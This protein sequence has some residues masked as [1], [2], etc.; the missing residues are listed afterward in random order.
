MLDEFRQ[1]LRAS[2]SLVAVELAIVAAIFVA[3]RY[4]LIFFSKTPYL[5][6]LGWISLRL[7]G[8]TWRDVGLRLPPNWMWLVGGGVAAGVAME[9]LELFVTQPLLVALTGK[10]PDLAEL[11]ALVGNLKLLV[12]W[13]VVSW[14]LAALG[15]ELVWRGYLM[16]RMAEFFGGRRG[17]WVA[18]LILASVVFGLAHADQGVTGVAENAFDGM[19]LGL[20]YCAGGRN[21]IMPIVAHGMTDTLDVSIIFFGCY[22]GM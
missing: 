13:I 22:P 6:A 2:K 3:D 15:E 1:S 5:L 16:N 4:H 11:H 7:R 10:F 14:T 17:G 21:L 18:T 9:L 19:L 20:L 8:V 12:V